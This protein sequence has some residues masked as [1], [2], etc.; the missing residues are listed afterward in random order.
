MRI[1]IVPLALPFALAFVLGAGCSLL[2]PAAGGEG[3]GRA[4]EGEGGEGEGVHGAE[5]EGEGSAGEG[6]GSGA[7]GEGSAAEGEGSAAEGEGEGAVISPD[8]SPLSTRSVGEVCGQWRSF[9]FPTGTDWTPVGDGSDTCDVGTLASETQ[10]AAVARVNLYRYLAGLPG[11]VRDDGLV[12]QEQ[13]CA[14]VENGI[15]HLDH[16]PPQT[17][18]CFTQEGSAGAGS[19][20]LAQGTDTVRSV[21]LFVDD[22]QVPSMGHRRW[23][24]NPTSGETAFGHKGAFTCMYSFSWSASNDPEFLSWPPAGPVPV[25][26]AAGRYWFGTSH[27]QVTSTTTISVNV[28]G[29]GFVDVPYD[30]L[31]YGYGSLQFN[32]GFDLPGVQPWEVAVE[33]RTVTVK[34]AGLDDGN[35][36]LTYSTH[37]VGCP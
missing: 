13:A 11:I 15:G 25:D 4:G 7:E 37:Y 3:E 1:H 18:P 21:D 19:S 27:H 29:A 12:A 22:G 36:T 24:L 30:V 34:V 33:G 26:A 32:L 8:S 5:G 9:A 16:F 14:N 17:A 31:D 20:N 35:T 23:V 6:E 10:D 2:T 28:D